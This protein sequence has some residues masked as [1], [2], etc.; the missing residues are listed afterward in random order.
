M[1]TSKTKKAIRIQAG[2]IYITFSKEFY[3]K[4]YS[5]QVVQ[6][7]KGQKFLDTIALP[8]IST[9]QLSQLECPDHREI[10]Q[11][12]QDSANNKAPG[13]D[14]YTTEF[15]K[16]LKESMTPVLKNLYSSVWEGGRFFPTGKYTGNPKTG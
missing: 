13:P 6:L 9:E 10:L 7:D 1:P 12:I 3:E 11:A 15:Y 14:G 5:E 8:T 4:L 16:I 2:G